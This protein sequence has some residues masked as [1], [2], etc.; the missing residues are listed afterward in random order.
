MLIEYISGTAGA[1]CGIAQGVYIVFRD[2]GSTPVP[3]TT[4]VRLPSPG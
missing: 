4:V 3:A 2:A 1:L